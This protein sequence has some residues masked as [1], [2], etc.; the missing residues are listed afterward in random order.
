[1]DTLLDKVGE[2]TVRAEARIAGLSGAVVALS[3][4]VD[5]SLLLTFA[6][7]VLP[8]GRLV[9]VTAVGS[10]ESE[11]DIES[12]AALTE[13]LGVPHQRLVLDSLDIP[14]FADNTPLRCYLCR[15][16]LYEALENI[17]KERGLEAVLDGAI[18]EDSEDYRPGLQAAKEAGVLHPLAEAGFLKEEVREASRRLGL[19]TAERPASPCLASR[20][21]YGERITL[22]GLRTVAQAE[23]V[24]H[25]WG[26][27]VVRVRH[28]DGGRL[29]RIEVPAEQIR[30]L[31]EE[32]LRSQVAG[33]LRKL[34]Y[35]Y[36]C[37]DLLGFRSGSLNEVLNLAG[38]AAPPA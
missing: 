30:R 26:F 29:A 19:P 5:S 7:K 12:A 25:G 36:V 20:F 8:E 16:Q 28:H 38:Q 13:R 37:V 2:K 10:V 11:E 21:P 32:P 23:D 1:V 35:I 3:G 31:C 15:G 4:G 9:A 34:G 6:A 18:A 33:A 22:E 27:P 14:G 24:L 17:R